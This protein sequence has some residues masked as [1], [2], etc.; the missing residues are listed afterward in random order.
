MDIAPRTAFLS[1]Y[2]SAE[3]RTA[4]MGIINV[5]K[6][7]SQSVGP[8]LTGLLASR[9]KIWMSFVIAGVLQGCYDLAMLFFFTRA[10]AVS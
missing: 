5:V 6:M 2:V 4:V 10:K 7:L 3:E 8:T 9:G 1:S